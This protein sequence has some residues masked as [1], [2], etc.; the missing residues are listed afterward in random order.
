MAA[1][2]LSTSALMEAP[3]SAATPELGGANGTDELAVLGGRIMDALAQPNAVLN[4]PVST[5]YLDA[6]VSQLRGANAL[7]IE[8]HSVTLFKS[9][10]IN[11]F[12][13]PGGYIGVNAGL[14]LAA[15]SES[16]LA[17][18][19]AHELAHLSQRH[20]ERRFAR[21]SG[22]NF[23]SLAGIIAGALVARESP[24]AAQ[25][26]IYSGIAATT[27]QQLDYSREQE[28]EADRVGQKMLETAGFRSAGNAEMLQRLAS[29]NAVNV[30]G[31]IE[32]LQSH[33]LTPNRIGEAWERA[34]RANAADDENAE[35][36]IAFAVVQAR[37]ASTLGQSVPDAAAQVYA[38]AFEQRERDPTRSLATLDSLDANW[39]RAR[40][41]RLLRAE[42]LSLTGQDSAAADA[43]TALKTDYPRDFL[44]HLS[45]A[46]QL[47]AQSEFA[48]ASTLLAMW[49]REHRAPN[50]G[51]LQLTAQYHQAAGFDAAAQ[52]WLSEYH[53]MRGDPQRASVHLKQA[54]ILLPQ[55]SSRHARVRAQLEALETQ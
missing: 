1:L 43:Y 33:P 42:L 35:D 3:S 30:A 23:A 8:V 11:A 15:Q 49:L 13:L 34:E 41:V 40:F 26:A 6:L 29:L 10:T 39:Q 31:G 19:L 32:Y 36:A 18:V 47:A 27:Q 37:M 28:R 24:D 9:L 5:A 51:V 21:Q 16:A 54:L 38:T 20:I 46:M 44:V 14:V 45:H 52:Q 53:L 48:A 50:P 55:D 17:S 4:D 2:L 22:A 12:V 7:P 25:A